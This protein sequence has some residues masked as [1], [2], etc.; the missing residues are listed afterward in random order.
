M[1]YKYK[2]ILKNK[3]VDS[4]KPLPVTIV[5]Q[6]K[7]KQDGGNS[8]ALS[9]RKLYSKINQVHKRLNKTINKFSK[10]KIKRKTRRR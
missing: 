4:K 6:S 2:N 7:E 3:I 1:K 9:T 8:K 5:D 10:K